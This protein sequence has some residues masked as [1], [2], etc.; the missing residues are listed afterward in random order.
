VIGD[1]TAGDEATYPDIDLELK[2]GP[3]GCVIVG[4]RCA[5]LAQ[6]VSS[7][8]CSD[9]VSNV[10]VEQTKSGYGSNVAR[11]KADIVHLGSLQ[12]S[13]CF[14][15][16]CATSDTVIASQ[17]IGGYRVRRREFLSLVGGVSLA[18]VAGSQWPLVRGPSVCFRTLL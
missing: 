13:I 16:V 3:D 5:L 18:F 4:A 8:R 10:S 17:Q 9:S 2:A 15:A 1:R 6:T 14:N 7:R 12:C 11:D